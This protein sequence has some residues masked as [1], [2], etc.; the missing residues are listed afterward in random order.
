M[1]SGPVRGLVCFAVA[2]VSDAAAPVG[3]LS[4]QN[5]TL[6]G[7]PET[8]VQRTPSP[9]LIVRLAGSYR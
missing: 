9:A 8:I 3:M 6:C 1:S 4:G 2:L 5:D 7:G